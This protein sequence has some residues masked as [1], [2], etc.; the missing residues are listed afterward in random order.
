L[1][2]ETYFVAQ[3]IGNCSNNINSMSLYFPI[4]A[5]VA[6]MFYE[7]LKNTAFLSNLSGLYATPQSLHIPIVNISKP[8]R[9]TD[10]MYQQDMTKSVNL[11]QIAETIKKRKVLYMNEAQK[12]MEDLQKVD[13]WFTGGSN[14]AIALTF[15]LSIIGTVAAMI[16]V[17]TCIRSHKFLSVVGTVM[18]NPQGT[19]AYDLD[20][21]TDAEDAYV[22]ER[23]SDKLFQ[24]IL[25]I[26]LYVLY[27]GCRYL[28]I[29]WSAIKILIPEA[30]AL[31][32][33]PVSHLHLEFGSLKTGLTKVYLGSLFMTICEIHTCGLLSSVKCTLTK[34]KWKTHGVLTLNWNDNAFAL[35]Y[36]NSALPLPEYAYVA[37]WTLNKLSAIFEETFAIRLLCTHDG[38]TY[39]LTTDAV[40]GT[41]NQMPQTQQTVPS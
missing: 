39:V 21:N 16:A 3:R 24:T 9:E 8:K 37:L 17:Y 15:V 29:R 26:I 18:A 14:W 33:G 12:D 19:Q 28:Y 1:V 27:K 5:A 30:I 34:S 13:K 23:L 10:V 41:P 40:V 11:K 2:G 20:S 38:L 36:G 25:L 32:K 22:M 31:Q 4:N 7:E 6:T 35:M